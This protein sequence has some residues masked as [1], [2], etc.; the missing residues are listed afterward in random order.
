MGFST[1]WRIK[2]N[3][4][5]G[6]APANTPGPEEYVLFVPRPFTGDVKARKRSQ[7]HFITPSMKPAAPNVLLR[8]WPEMFI[9]SLD[10]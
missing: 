10:I 4:S 8:S 1:C 7:K 3:N 2:Q 6:T 5:H 9:D